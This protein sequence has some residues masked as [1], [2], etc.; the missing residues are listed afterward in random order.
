MECL[1]CHAPLEFR[2]KHQIHT[3]EIKLGPVKTVSPA[4]VS[5]MP[6]AIY[7]CPQCGH[8]ELFA[9]GIGAARPDEER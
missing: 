5:G 3:G 8:I 6:V 4:F 1:R 2:G 9:P 7:L